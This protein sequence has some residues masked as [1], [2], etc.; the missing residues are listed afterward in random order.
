MML[1]VE[2]PWEVLA[3][4]FPDA[5]TRAEQLKFML[6]YAVLA[7]SNLNTQPWRFKVSGDELELYADRTRALPVIDPDDRELIMSCGAALFHL[8]TAM[9]HFGH[10]PIIHT[11]PDFDEPDLLAFV[12]MG[13][14]DE[15]TVTD[16]RLFEAIKDRRTNRLPFAPHSVPGPDLMALEAA[17]NLEGARLHAVRGEANRH[18]LADLVSE[19]DRIQGCD[20]RFRRELAAWVHPNRNNDGVPGYGWGISDILYYAGPFIMR[21]FDAGDGYAAQGRQIADGSPTLLVITTSADNPVA[22]LNAGQ[23]LER[24]LLQAQSYG[25]SASFLNQPVEVSSLR[26]RVAELIGSADYPQM[27]LRMGY[28]SKVR[29]TPRRPLR[30]VLTNSIYA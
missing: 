15:P 21:T 27:I 17:V 28:G 20:K 4:D 1:F 11:F 24:L 19:G 23:A 22:W 18:A 30:E 6:H 5:G 16:H 12:R 7:P 14:V 3:Y 9:R 10:R 26:P 29:P 2:D 8:R 25:L 13:G